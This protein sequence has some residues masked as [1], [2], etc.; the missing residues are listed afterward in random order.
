MVLSKQ[1]NFV[2]LVNY[3][4]KKRRNLCEINIHELLVVTKLLGDLET[5]NGR[6]KHS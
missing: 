6:S 1:M 3:R 4:E 2:G 5:I